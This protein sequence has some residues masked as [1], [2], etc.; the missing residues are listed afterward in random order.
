V[1][2][3]RKVLKTLKPVEIPA[4]YAVNA[5]VVTNAVVALLGVAIMAYLFHGAS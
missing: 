5:G 1:V 2:Q 3:Y 4:G